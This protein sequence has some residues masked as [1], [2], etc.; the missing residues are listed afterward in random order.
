MTEI[1]SRG[2]VITDHVLNSISLL[3]SYI[4]NYNKDTIHANSISQELMSLRRSWRELITYLDELDNNVNKDLTVQI[5]DLELSINEC[6]EKIITILNMSSLSKTDTKPA[7]ELFLRYRK[8]DISTNV[9]NE[10]T[11][12]SDELLKNMEID[13]AEKVEL[14]AKLHDYIR[15]YT[16]MF[17]ELEMLKRRTEDLIQKVEPLCDIM[18]N[19]KNSIT[20]NQND[21][22]NLKSYDILIKI[23]NSLKPIYIFFYPII[24]RNKR[25]E[26]DENVM[27]IGVNE[28]GQISVLFNKPMNNIIKE[29]NSQCYSEFLSLFFP[30]KL[31]FSKVSLD[32]S[33]DLAVVSAFIHGDKLV[34]FHIF[35]DLLFE[36]DIG[37]YICSIDNHFTE[38]ELTDFNCGIPYY[39]IQFI[40]NNRKVIPINTNDINIKT[41]DIY[42]IIDLRIQNFVFFNFIIYLISKSP[43]NFI[44]FISEFLGNGKLGKKST[45][46]LQEYD[47]T[48]T[49]LMSEFS[50]AFTLENRKYEVSI[51]FSG[52]ISYKIRK[53]RTNAQGSFVNNGGNFT[54]ILKYNQDLSLNFCRDLIRLL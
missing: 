32:K 3:R 49:H 27:D 12:L 10:L 37:D 21:T 23:P 51:N 14:E 6:W 25:I 45:C 40:I 42:K 33:T 16:K 20:E 30:I 17:Y 4:S 11:N 41:S 1:F 9:S 5:K 44:N 53:D 7:F 52:N 38:E 31:V 48:K 46:N 19:I 36:G 18:A 43:N 35:S 28:Y 13:L 50:F 54:D 24:I 8:E 39:W 34:K 29:S 15:E 22:D 26:N 2:T 47:I